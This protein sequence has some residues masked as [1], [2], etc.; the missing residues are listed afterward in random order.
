MK[1]AL[2][3]ALVLAAVLGGVYWLIRPK[4]RV[5]PTKPPAAAPAV[6]SCWAID[7]ATAEKALP[8]TSNATP[9]ASEHTAEVFYVGQ[10]G[11]DL[12]RRFD[13]AKK[14]K[15]TKEN[16]TLITNLL[17]AQA[18]RACVVQASLYLA[19]SWHDARLRV[20]AAWIAPAD[21]GF[22]GCALSEVDGPAGQ[23]FV[24]RT[25]SLK[26]ALQ[27]GD[28]SALAIACVDRGTASDLTYVGC[29]DPHDGE[30]VG[31]YTITPL[32]APYDD[33]GV[34]TA[35]QKG[36]TEVAAKYLNI[37]GT[38]GRTDLNAGSVGPK[39]ASDWLGSDQTYGCYAMSAAGRIKGS[40]KNLGL[41]PLPH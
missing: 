16:V 7:E 38:Q 22:Y 15:G 24:K 9:C 40:V 20:L 25:G 26:N 29:A 11:Q 36:C 32:D 3:L 17:Y 31:V 4:D 12:L 8:W 23:H 5:I 30:F 18:R 34:R 21:D 14:D 27:K 19:G 13:Q 41:A 35:A 39:S 28:A 33:A 2:I 1:R 6:G 37:V 10:A